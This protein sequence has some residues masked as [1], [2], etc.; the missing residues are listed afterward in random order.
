MDKAE[1][2]PSPPAMARSALLCPETPGAESQPA[3]T[4]RFVAR[5]SSVPGKGNK[6][7][8]DAYSSPQ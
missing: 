6:Y 4:L 1:D 7:G 8:G 3:P 5:R 2:R